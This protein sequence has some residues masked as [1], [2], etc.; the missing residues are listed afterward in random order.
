MEAVTDLENIGDLIETNLVAQGRM[1]LEEGI[2]VSERTR[3]VIA[4]VHGEVMAALREAVRA[5]VERDRGLAARVIA[6]KGEVNRLLAE[7]RSHQARRLLAHEPGRVAAYRIESDSL[8]QLHRIYY[9]AKRMAR[10]LLPNGAGS[11]GGRGL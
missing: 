8:E 4:G 5:V 6:R 10:T 7:A 1:R 11:E 3:E 9:F 2:H